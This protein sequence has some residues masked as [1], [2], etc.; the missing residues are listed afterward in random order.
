MRSKGS[1]IS[2]VTNSALGKMRRSNGPRFKINQFWCRKNATSAPVTLA[3]A[4]TF[5]PFLEAR[6]DADEWSIFGVWCA[7]DHLLGQLDVRSASTPISRSAADH[8]EQCG[9]LMRWE[10][11]SPRGL[12]EISCDACVR[13]KADSSLHPPNRESQKATHTQLVEQAFRLRKLCC[14]AVEKNVLPAGGR[15]FPARSTDKQPLWALKQGGA[16]T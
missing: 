15:R 14:T 9:E 5:A 7:L 16:V 8:C 10:D 4:L 13:F 12:W 2:I 11:G 6:L 3:A 1:F